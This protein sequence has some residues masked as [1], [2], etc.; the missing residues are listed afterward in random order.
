M[1]LSLAM[2]IL[3][4]TGAVVALAVWFRPSRQTA[5]QI[6]QNV[7]APIAQTAE[8][9]PLER[10]LDLNENQAK[11]GLQLF[12]DVR[13]SS[14]NSVSCSSCHSLTHG[15]VDGRRFSIGVNG[16]EGNIN[17]PTVFNS[18]LNF[19]Q[20]WN[21][22]AENLA[23]Q[24]EGPILNPIEM[25]SSWDSVLTKLNA[26]S[27][28][29]DQFALAFGDPQINRENVV[30]ALAEFERALITINSPFDA[31]LRGETSALSEAQLRGYH[32][33]QQYGC[34]SCHQGQNIGGNMFQTMGL[35]HDY[36]R[37][38]GGHL[39]SDDGRFAVTKAEKDRHVFKVPS[40]RNVA[41]TAPYFHDGSEPKL[42]NAVRKMA[43]YQLG[44][45][46]PENDV[47]DI[48]AFLNSLTGERPA[49]LNGWSNAQ[50]QK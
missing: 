22:R 19:R 49:I 40:L 48:V 23:A 47:R 43:R 39:E 42:E 17:A 27:K 9:R 32:K 13:L 44:R 6:Q 4:G 38:R 31:Y 8:I 30:T 36:F 25:G 7:A 20:F 15:G 14:N 21:G 26:D 50:A 16:H 34:I 2:R 46:L 35:A 3:L 29:R 11:L 10:P 45:V 37:E 41:V 33:F 1:H 18:S 28:L 5:D 12:T 24:A